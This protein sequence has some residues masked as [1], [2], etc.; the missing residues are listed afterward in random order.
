MCRFANISDVEI[1]SGAA[2]TMQTNERK[3]HLFADT[4]NDAKT[5]VAALTAAKG[6]AHKLNDVPRCLLVFLSNLV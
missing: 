3:Y 6:W 2:F 4:A 5:W 1:V